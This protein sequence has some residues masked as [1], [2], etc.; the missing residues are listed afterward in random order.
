MPDSILSF[1]YQWITD[2]L[3][4][5]NKLFQFFDADSLLPP[6]FTFLSLLMYLIKSI[7]KNFFS[8]KGSLLRSCTKKFR[9]MAAQDIEYRSLI[10]SFIDNFK[11][12]PDAHQKGI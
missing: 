8:K 2:K 12:Q 11:P 4:P 5:F 3:F 10:F 6:P 9:S 7:E 1:R